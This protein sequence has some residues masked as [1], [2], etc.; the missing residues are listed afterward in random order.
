M[1]PPFSPPPYVACLRGSCLC[2]TI[3]SQTADAAVAYFPSE[4]EGGTWDEK[5]RQ[6]NIRLFLTAPKMYHLLR[7]YVERLAH[8]GST[9]IEELDTEAEQLLAEVDGIPVPEEKK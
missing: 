6:A 5:V 8:S 7:K 2:G 3:W 4:H 1:I 9:F